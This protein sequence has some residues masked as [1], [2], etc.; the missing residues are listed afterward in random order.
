[1]VSEFAWG[2]DHDVSVIR[3]VGGDA[4][5]IFATPV[6]DKGEPRFT[7]SLRVLHGRL[8]RFHWKFSYPD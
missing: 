6:F 2:C 7:F 5:R 3:A 8:M 4:G 1:V